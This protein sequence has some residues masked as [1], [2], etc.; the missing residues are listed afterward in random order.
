MG[1]VLVGILVFL[2]NKSVMAAFVGSGVSG[3]FLGF[4]GL[5]GGVDK[6]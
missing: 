1:P 3:G 5:V 6:W 2:C 4:I